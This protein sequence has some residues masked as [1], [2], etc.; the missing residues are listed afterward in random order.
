[1]KYMDADL[2]NSRHGVKDHGSDL[3][4]LCDSNNRVFI[5]RTS[6]Q[7]IWD[8]LKKE[9]N[10][11]F[12]EEVV[13]R[14]TPSEFTTLVE[15]RSCGLQ[16]FIP[17]S[18]GDSRFYEELSKS[19]SFY[20]QNKWEFDYVLKKQLRPTDRVLDVGCG[21]GSFLRKIHGHIRE[22]IGIDTNP[23]AVK[24]AKCEGLEVNLADLYT[25]SKQHNESFDTVCCFHVVE[26]LSKVIPFLRAAIDCLK[27][28]GRLVLS[29][30]NRQRILR[31]PLEVLD[32]PPHHISRWRSGQ[33]DKLADITGMKLDKIVLE[34]A[35]RNAC[36]KWLREK[37][38][39]GI[40]GGKYKSH[41]IVGKVASFVTFLPPLYKFYKIVGLL[42]R[43]GLFRLSMLAFYRKG[44]V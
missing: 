44:L 27:D 42:E 29:V 43:W 22:A 35:D 25:F 9:W 13:R 19:P 39:N 14:N 33:L 38:T 26:H 23:A 8:A 30:P 16:Y 12:P 41:F 7:V 11:A 17:I 6:Y 1:M 36:H 21:E 18:S 3:C 5:S 4:P 40:L 24:R 34:I 32:C 15:C 20:D 2:S 10:T 28:N 31:E 37:I